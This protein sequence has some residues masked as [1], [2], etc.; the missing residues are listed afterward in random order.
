MLL[1]LLSPA[2]RFALECIGARTGPDPASDAPLTVAQ[3]AAE[4]RR[5]QVAGLMAQW[6][7][8]NPTHPAAAGLA[9]ELAP[10]HQTNAMLALAV[11]AATRE[12]VARL[13]DAGIRA[14]VLKGP[15]L[16]ARYYGDYATRHAGDVDLLTD[17][18]EVASADRVLREFGYLRTKPQR[19][20]TGRRLALY[21]RTQH[22]LGYRGDTAS[23]E[24]HWRYADAPELARYPFETLWQR[25]VAHDAGG[26][27]LRALSDRDTLV[28]LAVHG[29]MDGWSRLKWIADLPRV[30]ARL[31][32][33][34]LAELRDEARVMGHERMLTLALLLAGA[35]TEA[36]EWLAHAL[37]RIARR[38]RCEAPAG[39]SGKITEWRED[40]RFLRAVSDSRRLRRA[41]AYA[42]LIMP[43]DFDH[44]A[45]PDALTP[46]LPWLAQSRRAWGYLARTAG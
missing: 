26:T 28:H 21:L 42:N 45:L 40:R 9:R 18:A 30:R 35:R 24:L 1:P 32:A 7:E 5:Q 6:A 41:L 11:V 29:A 10:V 22:E 20:L 13:A 8:R 17:T 39:L 31:S 38:L 19:A 25:S 4:A 43:A 44:L 16:S 14:L 3:I 2:T 12:A 33:A 37:P 36:P 46:A 23:V 15:L 27:P 34:E